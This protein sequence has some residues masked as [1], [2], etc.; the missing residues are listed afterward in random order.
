MSRAN[1]QT[2][3]LQIARVSCF[4]AVLAFAVSLPRLPTSA[5][6]R[7]LAT[8]APR[9]GSV[10]AARTPVSDAP[11]ARQEVRRGR[12]AIASDGWE[13]PQFLAGGRR[14]NRRPVLQRGGEVASGGFRGF[15]ARPRDA[16]AFAVRERRKHRRDPRCA[17]QSAQRVSRA[18]RRPEPRFERGESGGCASRD[19]P[20]VEVRGPHRC[21]R[22]SSSFSSYAAVVVV[23]VG[24]TS[25]MS[26]SS[27]I[28]SRDRFSPS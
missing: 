6:V 18:H 7:A 2:G 4:R 13:R 22:A 19:A 25:I 10:C 8:T 16:R 14:R 5:I 26:T 17:S 3:S 23:V 15:R 12:R 11:R 28:G 20:R 27:S 21:F 9:A 1:R 24:S